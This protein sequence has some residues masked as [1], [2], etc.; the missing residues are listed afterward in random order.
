MASE[1]VPKIHRQALVEEY[2]H[3]ILASRD[4][5]ASSSA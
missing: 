1:F 5:L 3:A 2:L 4:S